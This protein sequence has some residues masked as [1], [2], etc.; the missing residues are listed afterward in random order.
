MVEMGIARCAAPSNS[1]KVVLVAKRAAVA[2]CRESP[3]VI[4]IVVH[5]V[6]LPSSVESISRRKRSCCIGSAGSNSIRF[7]GRFLGC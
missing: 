5:V 2:A 1:P 4:V 7:C 3:C 6:P